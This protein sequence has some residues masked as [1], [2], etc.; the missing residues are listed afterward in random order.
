MPMIS[1]SPQTTVESRRASTGQRLA[2]FVPSPQPMVDK[3]LELAEARPGDIVYDLGS[4][5]G[6]IVIT[7]AR[8]FG[9]RSTG[10]EIDA[11][12]VRLSTARIAEG[13]LASRARIVQGDLLS[14]DLRPATIVT[15]YQLPAVN[16][17]LRPLFE[18]QL[19]PGTRV[20]SLDF[21][22]PGWRA[23]Q[24]LTATLPDRSQHAI[25]LY[26]I[27]QTQEVT[28]ALQ[29]RTYSA[30]RFAIELDGANTGVVKSVEGGAASAD[31]VTEKLGPDG[32]RHKH[33]AGVKYDDII[34]TCGTGMS[35]S[36][37]SWIADTFNGKHSRKDGA[38]VG[39]DYHFDEVS[40]LNFFHALLSEVGFP[41]LDASSK[42]AAYL[43]V[44]LS[45]EYSRRQKAAGV[46]LASSSLKA[47]KQWL[48]NSFHLDIDG[49]DCK[50]VTNVDAI[51]VRHAVVQDP[52]GELRD[53]EKEPSYL[54]VS[55]L[56]IE[57]P[58][59]H[60]DSF[61]N[62]IEDFVI[63]GNN[64]QNAEKAGRLQYIAPNLNDVHF[65]LTFHN[66]GI[67]KVSPLKATSERDVGRS[68]RAEMYCEAISFSYGAAAVSEVVTPAT[69]T[70][71]SSTAS[72]SALAWKYAV[73]R[74]SLAPVRSVPV[75][76]PERLVASVRGP[77]LRFRG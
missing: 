40:R 39:G 55:N 44:A 38:I 59:A 57:L 11:D 16:E 26:S 75:E 27:G 70:G 71:T 22:V 20:V 68:V 58:E 35:K 3:M 8:Q 73:A 34:V 65:T 29:Q 18:A 74:S 56:A 15:L 31:V 50:M 48:R 52:V 66:L 77:G 63:K 62:W 32:I 4:G 9:A 60:A 45:P 12:L 17:L 67:F 64:G 1:A 7:A 42:E 51:T 25:Y 53:Y 43:T 30:E 69:K 41:A 28:M 76:L 72:E 10:I 19:R 33:V 37:Y 24:V 23:A 5:D 54:N 2:P 47:Q 6:Q 61:Y 36:F 46:K 13:G 21:P 49:L 14:T